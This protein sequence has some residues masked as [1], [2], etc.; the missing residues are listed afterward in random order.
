MTIMVRSRAF[1]MRITTVAASTGATTTIAVGSPKNPLATQIAV[2]A[3]ALATKIT[4]GM[5]RGRR[6]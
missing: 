3:I 4:A 6:R 1:G 2:A 5:T